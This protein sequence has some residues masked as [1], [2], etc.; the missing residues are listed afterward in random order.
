[1]INQNDE[2]SAISPKLSNKSKINSNNAIKVLNEGKISQSYPNSIKRNKNVD[3]ILNVFK[4]ENSNNKNNSLILSEEKVVQN[5]TYTKEIKINNN[6]SFNS[7]ND[8]E[9]DL[10]TSQDLNVSL[11]NIEVTKSNFIHDFQKFLNKVN[12]QI[13]NNFPVSLNEK[14]KHYF[15]QSNFWLLVM[16]YLFFLNNNISLYTIISLFEQYIIWC[17]DINIENFTA[18]KE[19]IKEYINS[20]YSSEI[21][22]QFLFMNKLKNID[23]IF[24]KYEIC[25]KN[26]SVNYKE[27]KINSLNLSNDDQIKCNCELCRDDDACI[28]KVMTINNKRNNI[29]NN[30]NLNFISENEVLPTYNQNL[31]NISNKEEFFVKGISKK[32][33]NIFSKSK[34]V[35]TENSNIEYITNNNN[36][37]DNKDE[38]IDDDNNKNFRNISKKKSNRN[39]KKEK[40]EK[41]DSINETYKEEEKD[42]KKDDSN[43]DSDSENKNKKKIKRTKR[44][45]NKSR[46]KKKREAK[47][48]KEEN[49][50]EEKEEKEEEIEDKE[51][52][53]KE[54]RSKSKKMKKDKKKNKSTEKEE[55]EKKE[56]KN[57]S[58]KQDEKLEDKDD[59][60]DINI[61]PLSKRKKSKTPNKKRNKKH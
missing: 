15:Q 20:N 12:I 6:N 4:K 58:E 36:K 10:N 23:E 31:N 1:M 33:K 46:N 19:R 43:S 53:K 56:E 26:K 37:Y 17:N 14:N 5:K 57:D 42:E 54:R 59:E 34:T 8:N 40:E 25:T 48:E 30:I 61:A 16:N 24:E 3:I 32:T 44:G 35:F 22:S 45:K 2:L 41:N 60:E 38:I 28:R 55:K 50:N 13:V 21:L 49:E 9:Q 52:E 29:N 51:E 39:K 27:I 7:N 11:S 47:F 18:I